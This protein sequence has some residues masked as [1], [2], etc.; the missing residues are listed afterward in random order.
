MKISLT[1]LGLL[2]IMNSTIAQNIV[3]PTTKKVDTVDSYFG[4]KIADPYRW[5]E[6]DNS[7]ETAEWVKAENKVTYDYLSRIPFRDNVKKRLTELWNYEKISAPFK[8]GS[9]YFFYKNDGIQ[10]QAV[11]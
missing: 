8:H 3:Y 5:L 9:N 4:K 6:D 7:T 2:A 10:N 11:L 1:S